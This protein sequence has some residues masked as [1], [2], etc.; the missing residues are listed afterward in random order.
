[1][2]SVQKCVVTFAS[3]LQLQNFTVKIQNNHTERIVS[4]VGPPLGSIDQ[5]AREIDSLT[6]RIGLKNCV[7]YVLDLPV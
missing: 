4:T 7:I 5:S 3:R 2:L 1:M 6:R